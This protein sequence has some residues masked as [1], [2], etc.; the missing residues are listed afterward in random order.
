[1]HL[2][3]RV[4]VAAVTGLI[5]LPA[6]A[7]PVEAATSAGPGGCPAPGA[8]VSEALRKFHPGHY[9]SVGRAELP[10]GLAGVVSK[11]VAGVQMRYR[12]AQLEPEEG[13]Y[14]FGAVARDLEAAK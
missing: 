13:Q 3:V 5:T 1:M 4:I 10:N 12:W 2:I 9:V 11:G 14:Q 8:P 7:A 6:L